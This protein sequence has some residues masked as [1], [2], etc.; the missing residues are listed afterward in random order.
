MHKNQDGEWIVEIEEADDG[1]GDAIIP[2]PDE[3]CDAL[4][5]QD[6]DKMNIVSLEDGSFV[7]ELAKK[8]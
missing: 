5:L 8:N 4:E 1:S 7:L 2:I 3:I 6:G